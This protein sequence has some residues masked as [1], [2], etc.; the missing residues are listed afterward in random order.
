MWD[1]I[2]AVH[3]VSDIDYASLEE[4][5]AVVVPSSSGTADKGGSG[6][7]QASQTS[8]LKR[9]PVVTLLA[10]QRSNNIGILLASL[11]MPPAQVRVVY[12]DL[13]IPISGTTHKQAS[14][15]YD[16]PS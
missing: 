3:D 5:F 14:K 1:L 12:S 15:E 2:N 10:V 8:R 9:A 6:S 13:C 11:K 7:H 4:L 16:K